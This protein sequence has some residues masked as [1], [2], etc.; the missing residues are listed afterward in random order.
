RSHEQRAPSIEEMKLG[1][2]DILWP[3]RC[4]LFALTS[5]TSGQSKSIPMTEEMLT[6]F[7]TAGREALL[8]YTA[9]TGHAR[10]FRGRHLL[11]GG[12]SALAAIPDAETKDV[13][14]GTASGIAALNL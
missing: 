9:R 6:H 2:A 13:F 4:A 3:G 10:V 14:T 1:A 7:R 5:G 11:L 8:Y 12:S